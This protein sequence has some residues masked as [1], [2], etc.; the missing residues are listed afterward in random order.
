MSVFD[1][2]SK[3]TTEL[4]TGLGKHDYSLTTN[5]MGSINLT[6]SI[7]SDSAL[8]PTVGIDCT[9]DHGNYWQE[10]NQGGNKQVDVAGMFTLDVTGDQDITISGNLNEEIYGT[11]TYTYAQSLDSTNVM[12]VTNNFASVQTQTSPNQLQQFAAVCATYDVNFVA[13][14]LNTSISLIQMQIALQ[15]YAINV[16]SF[17]INAMTFAVN[18][19]NIPAHGLDAKIEALGTKLQGLALHA[20]GPKIVGYAAKL[21]GCAMLG[22]NQVL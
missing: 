17:G 2:A 1:A 20:G 7:T 9:L 18:G 5:P 15:N 14:V 11:S 3:T 10:I 16:S 8:S 6:S 13:S 4:A 22:P 21:L 12:T 19:L